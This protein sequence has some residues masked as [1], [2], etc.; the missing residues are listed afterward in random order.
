MKAPR[1]ARAT[2]AVAVA[3]LTGAVA[4]PVLAQGGS[5]LVQR[6]SVL[7]ELSPT[8]EAGTSR[9][10][11]Q[12]TIPSG[13]T[14]LVLPNQSTSGLRALSGPQ[15]TVTSDGLRFTADGAARMVAD[16]TAPLPVSIAV[17]YSFDG[18]PMDPEDV[19]GRDGELTVTYTVRNLTAVPTEL[20]LTD[21]RG[22]AVTRS[23]DVAVPM[24]GSLMLTL[25]ARFDDVVA[26]GAVVV[27]DGRGGTVVNWSLVLFSPIGDETAEISYTATVQDAF[28]PAASAQVLPVTPDSFNSFI[29]TETAYR[30]AVDSTMELSD[31]A[32]EIDANLLRLADGAGRLLA[33]LVQLRDGAQQL[34][35]GLVDASDGAGRLAV[36]LGKARV[37]GDDLANG[38]NAL[39]KGALALSGG[40]GDLADGTRL[41]DANTALLAAGADQ[42]ADGA[43]D[44]S[45]GLALLAAGIT[46]EGGLP[47]A[48]AGISSLIAGIGDVATANTLLNGLSQVDGGLGQ[49][50]GGIGAPGAAGTLRDGVS[51]VDGG[52]GELDLGLQQ[53]AGGISNPACDPTNPTDP[54]NP[55]GLVQ[56]LEGIEAGSAD[57]AT[58]LAGV[59]GLL[60]TIDGT[61]LSVADQTALA[62]AIASIGSAATAGTILNG[63]AVIEA[64]ATTLGGGAAQLLAG[65]G[66]P[67]A[68]GT[69]RNGVAM[70]EAGM[71]QIDAGLVDMSN[72]IGSPAAAGT[73]RN[74][75]ARVTAGVSNPTALAG[76]P[77]CD[78]TVNP[79]N[80]CG[81]LEGLQVLQG[82]LSAALAETSAGLGDP[83][84]E[85]TLLWGAD[86]VANGSAG[87]AAGAGQLRS[88]GTGLVADGAAALAAGAAELGDGAAAAADGGS[89]LANGLSE[90]EAGGTQLADGL[91]TARTGSRDIADG[92]GGAHD[93]GAEIADGTQRLSAEGTSV[94]ADEVSNATVDA[95]L[96]LEQI[97]AAATR[98]VAG[99]GMPYP[100]IDGAVA[101]AVY[102]F[103]VAGVANTPGPGVLARTSIGIGLLALALLGW[104][105]GRR[106]MIVLPAERARPVI[107]IPEARETTRAR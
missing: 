27:G 84:T 107:Q 13:T 72:A 42:L 30:G 105:L 68:D 12:L 9:V 15:P 50:Q 85:G 65:I 80:P 63:L 14:N 23:V 88:E 70:L 46:G 51:Q 99:D 2:S 55:C 96:Q 28:I 101:S 74:G 69:L 36:G 41:L 10:F 57:L 91:D 3:L 86:Q 5:A 21:G 82:G 4:T 40:A 83:A 49:L 95:S 32:L 102:V 52:L 25:P 38:L 29:T 77:T 45:N 8:G 78:P 100:T 61:L 39:R 94:L 48:I 31:G 44:L 81:L 62:T 103:D 76:N 92:L 75:V 60:S 26:P 37:G 98:G 20:T 66:S 11:T 104:L 22:Q 34:S 56:G 24:V 79:A 93:G 90:L 59:Q 19:V 58:A 89:D 97:R 16:N 18:E 87:L 53:L 43:A 64:T 35:A 67:A 17:S 106:R 7:T 73:L 47:A 54:A 71:T 1:L 6:S 33:G